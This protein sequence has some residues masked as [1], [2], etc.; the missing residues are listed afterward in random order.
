LPGRDEGATHRQS[1]GKSYEKNVTGVINVFFLVTT[2]VHAADKI[3]IG[4]PDFNSSTFMLPL[5]HIRGF[6]EE[7]GLQA[8]LIRIRSAV[9]EA[10]SAHIR[11]FSGDTVASPDHSCAGHGRVL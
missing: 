4:Y 9:S 11:Q 7:E 10:E 1:K 6:F 5:A 2:S 8:E 3:R